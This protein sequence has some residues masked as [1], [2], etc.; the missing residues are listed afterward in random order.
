M[1]PSDLRWH[2]IMLIAIC[3]VDGPLHSQAQNSSPIPRCSATTEQL[4]RDEVRYLAEETISAADRPD[5]LLAQAV[6]RGGLL[7]DNHTQN[8]SMTKLSRSLRQG[9]CV[10]MMHISAQE[11]FALSP[12]ENR[13]KNRR[14]AH[15]VGH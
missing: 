9:H 14:Y 6:S 4:L 5:R 7:T 15:D 11:G 8:S 13:S 12:Q 1:T 10:G 2:T 3:W